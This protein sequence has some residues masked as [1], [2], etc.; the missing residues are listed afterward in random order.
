M[1]TLQNN[2]K[3]TAEFDHREKLRILARS[4]LNEAIAQGAFE[5]TRIDDS[6]RY[7]Y[8]YQDNSNPPKT[9]AKDFKF[10]RLTNSK[11]S[12]TGLDVIVYSYITELT[13][14]QNLTLKDAGG[15]NTANPET[16]VGHPGLK[17][18]VVKAT[19]LSAD[20][21]DTATIDYNEETDITVSQF[22]MM[23]LPI[24][25]GDK[26]Y[27]SDPSR[28]RI[29]V[30]D[31]S[32]KTIVNAFSWEYLLPKRDKRDK[33]KQENN[34]YRPGN[35]AL[36]PN[37]KFLA[38]QFKDRVNILCVNED[39]EEF[40]KFVATWSAGV[41]LIDFG[42]KENDFRKEVA[43]SRGLAFR[44]DGKYIYAISRPQKKLYTLEFSY[45]YTAKSGIINKKYE[46][47]VSSQ[48]NDEFLDIHV[49]HDGWI[50]SCAK[51]T[52][53]IFRQQMYPHNIA[54]PLTEKFKF[55]KTNG[56]AE[57]IKALCTTRDGRNIIALG[58]DNYL[59]WYDSET[60]EA[61][62]QVR[63]EL[64]D[65]NDAVDIEVSG[66]SNYAIIPIKKYDTNQSSII[67][68]KLPLK[69]GTATDKLTSSDLSSV[70]A[71]DPT[72]HYAYP[73]KC[74]LAEIILNSSLNEVVIDRDA[75]PELF[76]VDIKNIMSGNYS[77]ES[78]NDGNDDKLPDIPSEKII[79]FGD[80]NDVDDALLTDPDAEGLAD[81]DVTS[82]CTRQPEY[83][84]VGTS[85]KTIEFVDIYTERIN[86]EKV[87]PL[88]Y[89]PINLAINPAG[90]R[91]KATM[92]NT[93][94]DRPR[95]V[96]DAFTG[97]EITSGINTGSSDATKPAKA[98]YAIDKGSTS[99]EEDLTATIET[100]SGQGI[101]CGAAPGGAFD[102]NLSDWIALDIIAM[103]NGGFLTLYKDAASTGKRMLRWWGKY[104][105]PPQSGLAI[106]DY[107]SGRGLGDYDL[108]A[109]WYSVTDNFPPKDAKSLA[110]SADDSLLAFMVDPST[111]NDQVYLYDFNAQNFGHLTQL[112]GLIA[113]YRENDPADSLEHD[114]C[115]SGSSYADIDMA[116]IPRGNGH[117]NIKVPD[118]FSS[119]TS[120][121]FE[122]NLKDYP[123][124]FYK[125]SYS[126]NT[127]DNVRMFGYLRPTYSVKRAALCVR[128]GGRCAID[129]AFKDAEWDTSPSGGH[130][131][132]FDVN[133]SP[134]TTV[135]FQVESISNN[136][137][138]IGL[139]VFLSDNASIQL[140]GSNISNDD[141][142]GV[143][144]SSDANGG[145]FSSLDSSSAATWNKIPANETIAFKFRPQLL[146]SYEL[147]N[148]D[149][150]KSAIIF[151]RDI[152]DPILYAFGPKNYK[153][154]AQPFG[155]AQRTITLPAKTYLPNAIAISPDGQRLVVANTSDNEIFLI[156]IS[157]DSTVSFLSAA[158]QTAES[159]TS[160][161][162]KL[163][164][165]IKV[166]S[167]IL[168]FATRS[169]KRYKS[170][171]NKVEDTG[172]TLN[173]QVAGHDIM[174]L[175]DKGL[176][177]HRVK[178]GTAFSDD[179]D[180]INPINKNVDSLTGKIDTEIDQAPIEHYDGRVFV[181]NGE[182]SSNTDGP[183]VRAFEINSVT[184]YVLDDDFNGCSQQ[185]GIDQYNCVAANRWVSLNNHIVQVDVCTLDDYGWKAFDGKTPNSSDF[186]WHNDKDTTNTNGNDVGYM[187]Y[188]FPSA[189]NIKKIKFEDYGGSYKTANAEIK[190]WDE[191]S[192]TYISLK[193]LN[194][195]SYVSGNKW[196]MDLSANTISSKKYHFTFTAKTPPYGIAIHEIEIFGTPPREYVDSHLDNLSSDKREQGTACST[197]YGIIL[198]GGL[199][200]G[201][202]NRPT[203]LFWPQVNRM[204]LSKYGLWRQI[205]QETSGVG[206]GIAYYQNNLYTLCGLQNDDPDDE[207]DIESSELNAAVR[208]FNF[209]TN[210][211]TN[212]PSLS[213]SA[214]RFNAG[215]ANYGK[216]IYMI[217]GQGSDGDSK[218]DIVKFTP[219]SKVETISK[220]PIIKGHISAVRCGPAIYYVGGGSNKVYRYFP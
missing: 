31:P 173:A 116:F 190:Y 25:E 205:P 11:T 46:V 199:E 35:I 65:D 42:T 5:V 204:D 111:G 21:P 61:L 79:K 115:D 100:E 219:P 206:T 12:T 207:D 43:K 158:N 161:F 189:V 194:P 211:W 62:N 128:D 114:V 177:V 8:I 93:D 132:V 200:S 118:A 39:M 94:T 38:V 106:S 66:D 23:S 112:P 135:D 19:W 213:S 75:L 174:T 175:A 182:D 85:D 149:Q 217:S 179:F 184:D 63:L 140:T 72:L 77:N 86:E 74:S 216:S 143:G 108:F 130:Q 220:D 180:L 160:G 197:P 58:K 24:P 51:K 49:G 107:S 171:A 3:S 1:G 129:S 218:T 145:R 4:R 52:K 36:S 90:S 55:L 64:R 147:T 34:S 188:E 104:E 195:V 9:I 172:I 176:Y 150:G 26:I 159:V 47:A 2:L 154:F 122:Q 33:H 152:S 54:S 60:K 119:L 7:H 56:D 89:S 87:V 103:N 20:D 30:I 48:D 170:K 73:G 96:Y 29:A 102:D 191:S 181:I 137:E 6:T 131:R 53:C 210:A 163:E 71:S 50:Y 67:G 117:D 17:A 16:L 138:G 76:L 133:V 136:D 22:C 139:T 125:E 32:V 126:L 144:K 162:G 198:I 164:A 41:T 155:G 151:S 91:V 156:N 83:V 78:P 28:C 196:E 214:K 157:V 167:N 13:I 81:S 110:I 203:T 153:I 215:V 40:G 123:G 183:E 70:G 37:S 14:E 101:Y 192:S 18:L 84:F 166:P 208:V 124:N 59:C 187:I 105:F 113:D 186:Y 80:E 134:Y 165:K 57:E 98:V 146:H 121:P 45:D 69:D 168:C 95:K 212:G 201:G 82:I 92:Q 44:P 141:Y 193:T 202:L 127:R 185:N 99:Y 148:E 209:S 97:N 178:A 68:L 109:T 169:F 142:T 88:P 10:Y 120:L 27:C 15:N